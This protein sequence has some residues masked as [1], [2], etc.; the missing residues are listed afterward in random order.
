VSE[1]PIDDVSADARYLEQL[2]LLAA[3]WSTFDYTTRN[4]MKSA[5]FLLAS[6]LVP[7]Q[8]S[9]KK[10]FGTWGGSEDEY[11]REWVLSRAA[12]VSL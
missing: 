12:D 4:A 7:V 6:Q 3:N 5:P 2:R 1:Q 11:E 8:K 10:A 9:V